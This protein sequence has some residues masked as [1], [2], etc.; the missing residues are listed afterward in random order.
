[1]RQSIKIILAFVAIFLS[2]IPFGAAKQEELRIDHLRL[3]SDWGDLYADSHDPFYNA[4]VRIKNDRLT[5]F[6]HVRVTVVIPELG[7]RRSFSPF[8]ID[9]DEYFERNYPVFLGDDMD[10]APG[11]YTA[12]ITMSESN[13]F[14]RV[15][16]RDIEIR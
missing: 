5:D 16:H 8:S 11:V 9:A 14:R 1:M 13:G 6:D 7:W 4:K 12:R 2:A 3:R 15:K 10:V